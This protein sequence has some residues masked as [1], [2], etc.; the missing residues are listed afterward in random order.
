MRGSGK[1]GHKNINLN[2]SSW[3]QFLL[4]LPYWE[5]FVRENWKCSAAHKLLYLA[6][7]LKKKMFSCDLRLDY[8]IFSLWC[9]STSNHLL[10]GRNGH[11]DSVN[12]PWRSSLL[13]LHASLW[14]S[15]HSQSSNRRAHTHSLALTFP[16]NFKL[17]TNCPRCISALMWHSTSNSASVKL[18]PL[19]PSQWPQISLFFITYLT[20]P[21][22]QC[23]QALSHLGWTLRSIPDS[24]TWPT[25]SSWSLVTPAYDSHSSGICLLYSIPSLIICSKFSL[26]HFC[27]DYYNNLLMR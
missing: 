7:N 3:N 19:L 12:G 16:S 4:L 15:I 25:A 10:N 9:F 6:D 5:P 2:H 13:T 27:L 18:N 8:L 20:Y 26:S 22:E 23:H 21:G 1:R 14:A 11:D 17:V 24:S